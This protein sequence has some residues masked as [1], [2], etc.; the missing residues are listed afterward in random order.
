VAIQEHDV[1]IL[2]SQV[3]ADVPEGGGAATGIEVIDG[4][5]NNLFPD[6]SELDR[7]YG[8][9]N[10]RKVFVGIRTQDTDGY[11]GAHVIVS[12]P[13]DDDDVSCVLFS[14]E[15]PFDTRASAASRVESYLAQGAV[16]PGLL[17]GNHLAGQ[18][19]VTVAQRTTVALPFVGSTLVL[20]KNEG[21]NTQA[22]QFVR[23]VDVSAIE[24]TF[25]DAEGD[26]TRLISCRSTSQ[27]STRCAAIRAS[28]TPTERRPTTPPW[29]TPLATTGSASSK[30]PAQWA[31]S[32]CRP[33][34]S[35]RR[36][37]PARA[38]KRPSPMRE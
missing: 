1:Q 22:E 18:M 3:L 29:P 20:R 28:T 19:T 30:A 2:K 37:C 36:S 16:Y 4:Q 13:P 26:F 31:T 15:D 17:F 21:L 10:L 12:D 34:A 7:V 38:L 9:V 33:T 23:L 8:A 25:T 24:R 6:I 11:F 35:F 14:T 32:P 27:D 5:S